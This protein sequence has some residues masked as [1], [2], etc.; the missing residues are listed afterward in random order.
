MDTYPLAVSE[1][2]GSDGSEGNII[3]GGEMRISTA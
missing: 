2:D 1:R 3:P